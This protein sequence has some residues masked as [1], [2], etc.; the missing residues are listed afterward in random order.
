[1]LEN[2]FIPGLVV[3]DK[4]YKTQSIPLL[5]S[6]VNIQH[7]QFCWLVFLFTTPVIHKGLE[8]RVASHRGEASIEASS[9]LTA[10][11]TVHNLGYEDVASGLRLPPNQACLVSLES[12][13]PRLPT[14]LSNKKCC[15]S[16]RVCSAMLTKLYPPIA[17]AIIL[18][19]YCILSWICM[20]S[21]EPETE[22]VL[23]SWTS[24]SGRGKI[25]RTQPRQGS[26][27]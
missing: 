12:T 8:N 6:N 4:D 7:R 21:T 24:H 11:H 2:Y 13:D 18:S 9:V 15:V 27:L 1:M 14:F 10:P 16:Y 26:L 23:P 17:S 19:T 5:E 22:R 20:L 25:P 3:L